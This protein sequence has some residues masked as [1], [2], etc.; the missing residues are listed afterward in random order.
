MTLSDHYSMDLFNSIFSSA[1][2]SNDNFSFL[3]DGNTTYNN[4][5]NRNIGNNQED[6][7]HPFDQSQFDTFQPLESNAPNSNSHHHYQQ[8]LQSSNNYEEESQFNFDN[9]MNKQDS[10]FSA[11]NFEFA[12]CFASQP[13]ESIQFNNNN[14]NNLDSNFIQQFHLSN[15]PQQDSFMTNRK[16]TEDSQIKGIETQLREFEDHFHSKPVTKAANN[17][18]TS[19]SFQHPGNNLSK[20]TISNLPNKNVS[21]NTASNQINNQNNNQNNNLVKTYTSNL[22]KQKP[23]PVIINNRQNNPVTSYKNYPKHEPIIEETEEQGLNDS[24]DTGHQDLFNFGKPKTVPVN[25]SHNL[26][27]SNTPFDTQTPFFTDFDQPVMKVKKEGNV[28]VDLVP[29]SNNVV[30]TTDKP[31]RKVASKVHESMQQVHQPPKTITSSTGAAQKLQ[32]AET[33]NTLSAIVVNTHSTT[34]STLTVSNRNTATTIQQHPNNIDV[35][36]IKKEYHQ[37]VNSYCDKT[38]QAK[39]LIHFDQHFAALYTQTEQFKEMLPQA[40]KQC[41][42][43]YIKLLHFYQL[44]V[45]LNQDTVDCMLD[46]CQQHLDKIRAK[47]SQP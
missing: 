9:L 14:N 41:V 25:N 43:D 15:T 13:E 27:D 18:T 23:A 34:N 39:S 21:S 29:N 2:P 30:T 4:S 35:S 40:V 20:N 42:S 1:E 10:L 46:E 22:P 11:N 16:Q 45:S 36:T 12:D 8:Q 26:F 33:K 31:A 19:S 37:L 47:L 38:D 44:Y 17:L 3:K 32:K 24:S 7:F 28:T 6:S 5:I